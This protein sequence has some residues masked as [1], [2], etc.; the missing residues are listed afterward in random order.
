M[1]I[2]VANASWDKK[3]SVPTGVSDLGAQTFGSVAGYPKVVSGVFYPDRRQMNFPENAPG[4]LVDFDAVFLSETFFDGR[5]GDLVTVNGV[6]MKC[7]E[8]QKFTLPFAPS[9]SHVEYLLA[10]LGPKDGV[11]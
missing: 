5:E 3:S 6:T 9:V 2:A 8:A 10:Y 1:G 4:F 11:V 7:V